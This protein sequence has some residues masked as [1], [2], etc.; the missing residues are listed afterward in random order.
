MQSTHESRQAR[1]QLRQRPAPRRASRRVLDTRPRASA[2]RYDKPP[3]AR[4]VATRRSKLFTERGA[5]TSF[6]SPVGR[7]HDS[8]GAFFRQGPSDPRRRV[9]DRGDR[10]VDGKPVKIV[11]SKRGIAK[12]P[13]I[14]LERRVERGATLAVRASRCRRSR[15]RVL[16][17]SSSGSRRREGG[18]LL[19]QVRELLRLPC[20]TTCSSST[21]LVPA[22]REAACTK[23]DL[24]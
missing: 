10:D 18:R 7:P 20:R 2:A 12:R 23:V 8:D 15:R 11:A 14:R 6:R 3:A 9:R 21:G 16:H 4:S 1:D 22:A 5:L 17:F 24:E 13:V 19:G